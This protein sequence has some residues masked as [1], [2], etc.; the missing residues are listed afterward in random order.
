MGYTNIYRNNVNPN[1]KY[2]KKGRKARKTMIENKNINPETNS[3]WV[4]DMSILG[5]Y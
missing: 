3:V 2:T 5:K 1:I 4:Y